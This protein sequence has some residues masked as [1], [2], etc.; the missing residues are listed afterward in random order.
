M[1]VFRN[2]NLETTF[3]TV[4]SINGVCYYDEEK[5]EDSHLGE[6][7]KLFSGAGIVKHVIFLAR[8]EPLNI[9]GLSD[10]AIFGFFSCDFY[11]LCL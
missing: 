11:S 4:Y 2:R 5:S 1:I 3:F 7:S 6:L 10:E 8:F 9:P